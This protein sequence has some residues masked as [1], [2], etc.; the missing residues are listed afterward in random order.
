MKP[1]RFFSNS[2]KQRA[3]MFSI[4]LGIGIA[5]AWAASRSQAAVISLDG[6]WLLATDPQNA[7]R[8]GHWWTAPHSEAEADAGCRGSSRTPFRV[9]TGWPGIGRSSRPPPT[10]S[11][12]G[13]RCC[14]SGRWTTRP[15]CGST[16]RPVG[17]HEGGES[18]FV[19]RR[20]RRPEAGPDEP[21]GR[22]R[23]EPDPPTHRRHR[24]QRDST[25]Q[26]GP[27]V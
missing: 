22:A 9:T 18:P 14:A 4:A 11:R 17:S 27:A 15:T 19:L 13:A 20:H 2:M 16:T 25:P 24:A 5:A 23:A 6:E 1:A 10:P 12:A 8:D 3:R 21:A 7:G 26:Q